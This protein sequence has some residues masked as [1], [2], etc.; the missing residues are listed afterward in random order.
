M[1]GR[2]SV[3][4]N[5]VLGDDLLQHIPHDRPRAFDHA[6]RALDVLRVVEVDKTLHDEGL[7]ELKCHLLGQ[8]ALVQLQ[9]RPDDDNRPA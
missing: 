9:L 1:Q 7:E 8:T 4:Q 5:R 2:R 3:Q 6:L